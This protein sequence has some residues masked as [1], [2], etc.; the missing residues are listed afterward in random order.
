MLR[1]VPVNI[2]LKLSCLTLKRLCFLSSEAVV[3]PRARLRRVVRRAGLGRRGREREGLGRA[4]PQDR[5]RARVV[6]A[7]FSLLLLEASCLRAWKNTGD[8]ERTLDGRAN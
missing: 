1:S 6:Q 3:G 5:Q 2:A 8:S 7:L 4:G